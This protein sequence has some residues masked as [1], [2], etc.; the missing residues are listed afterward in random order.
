MVNKKLIEI[1]QHLT[2]KE[3]KELLK[4][5]AS[6]YH[7]RAFD[8]ELQME[9]L[10]LI[11]TS[12]EKGSFDRLTKAYLQSQF[13]PSHPFK[14]KEKN[15]IDAL[16]SKLL[17][18]VQSF[19]YFNSHNSPS[20]EVDKQLALAKFYRQHNLEHR[21]WQTIKQLKRFQANRKERGAWYYLDGFQIEVEVGFFKSIFNNYLDDANL[22]AAHRNL[23]K[24]FAI[25]KLENAAALQFQVSLNDQEVESVFK[26]S[27]WLIEEYKALTTTQTP[28][29]ELYKD[30]ISMLKRQP[31]QEEIVALERKILANREI[32]PELNLRNLM[33]YQRY[34]VIRQ[35]QAQKSKTG[36]LRNIFELFQ[37]H[38]AAGYFDIADKI[39]PASLKSLVN[40]GLKLGEEEWVSAL[41]K[42]YPPNR[43][44]G[45]KYPYEAHGLCWA[46][47]LFSQGKFIEAQDH[48]NYRKFENINYSILADV[49]LI[50]IY[51]AT[52]DDLVESRINALE[53][54]VRRSRLAS[55]NKRPYLNFLK[56]VS[57]YV[58]YGW[59]SGSD[60][61]YKLQREVEKTVPLIEREWLQK[62]M[63]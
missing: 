12:L 14:D 30:L 9:L 7:N 58:K 59:E 57:A 2:A 23:D 32:M 25:L 11:L 27:D 42:E 13:Y 40:T 63:S 50:K 6:P 39:L 47:L 18:L 31:A 16:A 45:T 15:L 60:R 33:A 49:L 34:F 51:L 17:R 36:Q 43:I 3:R 28:L 1:L 53:Q 61:W 26:I 48:L 4:F 56:I 20:V 46:E 55:A 54:K 24:C 52:E 8:A 38:L 62:L 44:T 5:T 19:L 41:L 22:V 10:K 37:K 35:Y 21:F 29:A